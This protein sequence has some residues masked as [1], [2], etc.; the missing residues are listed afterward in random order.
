MKLLDILPR[1]LSLT[2]SPGRSFMP[3]AWRTVSRNAVPNQH[4]HIFALSKLQSEV[5]SD[6][7]TEG[8]TVKHGV[9]SVVPHMCGT[10]L[11]SQ[12]LRQSGTCRTL[13]AL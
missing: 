3:I 1:S 4:D 9:V 7:D 12:W 5:M 13:L 8:S 2:G 6:R 11:Q 10:S